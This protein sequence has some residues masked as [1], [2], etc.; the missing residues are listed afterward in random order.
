MAAHLEQF[1]HAYGYVA[2]F[3]IIALENIGLPVPGETILITSAVF[4]GTTHELNIFAVVMTAT[5]AAFAGSAVGCAIGRYG[6][7]RFLHRYGRYLHIDDSDLRLGRYLFG[8]YG[9][10]VVFA[11]RFVAFLRALAGLLAGVNGMR[12]GRFLLFSGRVGGGRGAGGGVFLAGGGPGA[13]GGPA[14]L[15]LGPS[16]RGGRCAGKSRAGAAH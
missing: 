2:V 9:G 11:A 6:E 8:R 7:R 1:L 13:G 14:P 16:L 10:R 15:G 5:V 4:A 3:A 12:G